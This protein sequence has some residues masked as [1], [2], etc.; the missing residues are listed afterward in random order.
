M[1]GRA[2]DGVPFAVQPTRY[3]GVLVKYNERTAV[4]VTYPEML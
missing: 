3:G 4:A 2:R 1:Y